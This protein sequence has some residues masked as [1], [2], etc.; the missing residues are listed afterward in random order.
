[1][2]VAIIGRS[3]SGKRKLA[4]YLRNSSH[5]R[6]RLFKQFTTREDYN[7]TRHMYMPKEARDRLE[8]SRIFYSSCSSEGNEYFS[9]TT[10][11]LNGG[12]LIYVMDDPMSIAR[13][14]ELGLPYAVVY[15]DCNT[16]V[17][18]RKVRSVME[19]FHAVLSRFTKV[20]GRLR[21][22]E[23]LGKYNLYINTSVATQSNQETMMDIFFQ[24]LIEWEKTRSEGE[25]H[26]K[27]FCDSADQGWLQKARDIG[28]LMAEM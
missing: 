27:M 11:F 1:M 16:A 21:R 24:N 10:Q 25:L 12:D 9:L 2:I 5:G 17:I 18:Y 19:L 6:F 13:I 28:F 7:Q 23:R 14:D 8:P 4:T 26:P 15:V 3:Y 22:M 20:R